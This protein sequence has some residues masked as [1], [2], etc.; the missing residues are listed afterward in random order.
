MS[1]RL[2]LIFLATLATSVTTVASRA[3]DAKVGEERVGVHT[4]LD[5]QI[6]KSDDAEWGLYGM[7]CTQVSQIRVHTTPQWAPY[8][9]LSCT[10]ASGNQRIGIRSGQWVEVELSNG[11]WSLLR[12]AD[13]RP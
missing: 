2:L 3:V 11:P 13:R 8:V 7:K 9:D 1:M 6:D 10:K 5:Y 12:D 4:R